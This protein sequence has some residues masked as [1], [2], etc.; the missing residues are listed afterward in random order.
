V[1]SGKSGEGW[2]KQV[3]TH[4]IRPLVLAL[5]LAAGTAFGTSRVLTQFPEPGGGAISKMAIDSTRAILYVS[6]TFTSLGGKPRSSLAAISLTSGAVLPWN[7]GIVGI[8]R[9][10]AVDPATGIVY[11]GGNFTSIGGIPRRNLAAITAAGMVV[12]G[13][14]PQ[15]DLAVISL[16]H[17]GSRLYVGGYFT[18]IGGEAVPYFAAL[19]ANDAQVIGTFLPQPNSQVETIVANASGLW[20]GGAF[21]TIGGVSRAKLASI[22]PNTGVAYGGFS[23]T[24]SSGII[25]EVV[26]GTDLNVLYATGNISTINGDSHFGGFAAF[27]SPTGTLQSWNPIGFGSIPPA[28]PGTLTT[29]GGNIYLGGKFSEVGGEVRINLAAI[30]P[31]ANTTDWAPTVD[32]QVFSM[33]AYGS[34]IFVSGTFTMVDGVARNGF[35]AINDSNLGPPLKPLLVPTLRA[36]GTLKPRTTKSKITLR[37]TATDATLVEFSAGRGG[38][39][40]AGG[41][42]SNWKIPV[43]LKSP[44]TVVN[45]RATG[46]GGVSPLL[47]FTIRRK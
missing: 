43:R 17:F 41:T 42:P 16:A 3:L 15:P 19:N 37:G 13:W 31:G 8:I 26:A 39:K 47:K 7:P 18:N 30:D 35:A 5:V 1:F 34:T 45:V 25:S 36:K 40:P 32:G 38:F 12:A 24:I 9:A 46:P 2:Q 29:V 23:Q 22:N 14:D 21:S 6:G 10:L 44:K 27:A 11:L 4:L 28:A 33:A 20:A